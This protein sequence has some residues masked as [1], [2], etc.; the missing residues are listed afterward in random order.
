MKRFNN[1]R[2]I[3]L[4]I[5]TILLFVALVASGLNHQRAAAQNAPRQYLILATGQG[6]GSTD[7]ADAIT[8]ANGSVTRMIPSI[9]VALASSSDPNFAATIEGNPKVSEV[10]EDIQVQWISPTNRCLTPPGSS[11]L[12]RASTPSLLAGFNGT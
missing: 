12:H 4:T 10:A 3:T 1:T 11:R 2:I 8:A 7:F 9:G 6:P 5:S